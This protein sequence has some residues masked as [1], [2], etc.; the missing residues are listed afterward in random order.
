MRKAIAANPFPKEI[1]REPSKVLV[2]FLAAEPPRDAKSNLAKFAALRMAGIASEDLRIVVLRDLLHGE[3]H[4]VVLARL[5]GQWLT[6]DN[7]RMAMIEDI[8]V[9]N[10]RPLFVIDRDGVM[11]YEEQ[12]VQAQAMAVSLATPIAPATKSD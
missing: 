3:D 5:D 1:E 9:R 8:D 6:L 7:Q 11:R 10:H 12:P 4:A 2:T